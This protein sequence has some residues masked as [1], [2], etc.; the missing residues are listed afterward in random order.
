MAHLAAAKL[1]YRDINLKVTSDAYTFTSPSSPDAPSLVIDRPMGDIRLVQGGFNSTKRATRVSSI[2]GI[3]G[4]IQLPLGQS[5]QSF[6][7]ID[8][9]T[10]H[11]ERALIIIQIQ[12]SMSSSS[13]KPSLWEGLRGR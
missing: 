2:S 5:L 1:P 8:H 13:I 9:A 10:I 4:I 7:L 11:T 6:G 3:L 12:T